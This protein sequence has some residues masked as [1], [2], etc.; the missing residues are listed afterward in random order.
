M[1]WV[2]EMVKWRSCATKMKIEEERQEEP[3]FLNLNLCYTIRLQVY[4]VRFSH[5]SRM[6]P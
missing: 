2:E 6:H 4:Y 3:R 5:L 1:I